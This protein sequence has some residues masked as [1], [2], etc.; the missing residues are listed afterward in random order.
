MYI[1]EHAEKRLHILEEALEV[2][3]YLADANE[4]ESWM[5]E[6]E[7]LVTNADFG[8]DGSSTKVEWFLEQ[9]HRKKSNALLVL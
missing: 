2:Q 9:L 5:T 3:Q 4:A 6:K 7:P 1:Q 8:K